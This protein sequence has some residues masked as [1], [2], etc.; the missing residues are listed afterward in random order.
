MA[1]ARPRI[2]YLSILRAALRTQDRFRRTSSLSA[3]DR[4]ARFALNLEQQD[5]PADRCA[6]GADALRRV[7]GEPRGRDL[8]RRR[9]DRQSRWSRRLHYNPTKGHLGVVVAPAVF[10]FAQTV[11]PLSRSPLRSSAMKSARELQSP[12]FLRRRITT[13]PRPRMQSPWRPLAPVCDACRRI[14]YAKRS[15]SPSIMDRAAR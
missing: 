3:I 11:S 1:G 14:G 2:R 15:G 10:A 13:V 5:I 9:A 6:E 7:G 4:I 8:C 12:F